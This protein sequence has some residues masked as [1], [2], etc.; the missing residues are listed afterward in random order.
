[1][2]PGATAF[3]VIPVPFNSFAIT[4]V[5]TSIA[6]FVAAYAPYPSRIDPTVD[7]DIVIILPPPPFTSLLAPSLQHRNVPF[8]FTLKT[9]SHWL[10]ELFI[11]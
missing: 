4:L 11:I 7:D 5:I 2:G 3:A 8:A 9:L 1:M 10:T 6:A